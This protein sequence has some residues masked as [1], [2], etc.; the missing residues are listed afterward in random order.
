MDVK[1]LYT[2]EVTVQEGGV[3]RFKREMS[4]F[5]RGMSRFKRGV[6]QFKRDVPIKEEGV[7]VSSMFDLSLTRTFLKTVMGVIN[8]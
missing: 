6:S 8:L 5:K 7:S 4:R 2:A 1:H 3:F